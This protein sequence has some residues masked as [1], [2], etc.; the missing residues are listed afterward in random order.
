MLESSSDRF[1]ISNQSGVA[2]FE[3]RFG[4]DRWSFGRKWW[5]IRG[6]AEGRKAVRFLGAG[7]LDGSGGVEAGFAWKNGDRGA[8][9]DCALV[10]MADPGVPPRH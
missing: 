1:R 8:G 10:S 2:R 9:R 5:E 6:S 7:V 4:L 3:L